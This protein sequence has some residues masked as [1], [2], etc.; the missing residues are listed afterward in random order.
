MNHAWCKLKL[1]LF[2]KE[3]RSQS[4][5]KIC[6]IVLLKKM[7]IFLYLLS[8]SVC[9]DALIK[10]YSVYRQ[11]V[12]KREVKVLSRKFHR[13]LPKISGHFHKIPLFRNSGNY[14]YCCRGKSS[15]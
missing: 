7:N 6:E 1:L 13:C 5:C 3:F 4:S 2:S 14:R 15:L 9:L 11:Y 10:R 12:Y 8:S